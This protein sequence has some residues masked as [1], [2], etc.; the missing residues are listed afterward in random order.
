[1]RKNVYDNVISLSS[2]IFHEKNLQKEKKVQIDGFSTMYPDLDKIIGG[3]INGDLIV[4]G[5]CTSVGKTSFCLSLAVNI[6]SYIKEKK[7]ENESNIYDN[8][9]GS[10]GFISIE[11][12]RQALMFRL[13]G[14]ISGVSKTRMRCGDLTDDEVKKI[15][16]VYDEL[17]LLDLILC[18]PTEIFVSQVIKFSRRMVQNNNLKILFI[19]YLQLV[20]C[21][22]K[23][24]DM[25]R[26]DEI[27][28]ICRSL[29]GLAKELN[30]PIV[31]VS[32]LNRDVEKRDGRTPII[33]NL[34]NSSSIEQDADTVLFI[35]RDDISGDTDLVE[36]KILVV[37]NRNG[38]RGSAVL[39]FDCRTCCFVNKKNI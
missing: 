34:K 2:L 16:S 25:N 12:S 19:D 22:R 36:T 23:T 20:Y 6:A 30:I 37:K 18:N 39:Y 1:M 32:Q 3:L 13:I 21:Y 14:M 29:K 17:I 24:N 4:I 7:Q 31:V 35:H 33:S 28:L 9:I 11:M 38:V 8:K 27:S 10:V 15:Q 26:S 5:G